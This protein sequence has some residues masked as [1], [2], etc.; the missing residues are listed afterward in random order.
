MHYPQLSRYED[1][2]LDSMLY[3]YVRLA[4]NHARSGHYALAKWANGMQ[5]HIAIE[6]NKRHA[7][8]AVEADRQEPLFPNSLDR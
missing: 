2:Q 4:E 3:S 1:H 5:A 6:M 8:A 7:A